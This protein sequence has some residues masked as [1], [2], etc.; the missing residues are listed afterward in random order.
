M[1]QIVLAPDTSAAAAETSKRRPWHAVVRA[2]RGSGSA[3]VGFFVMVTLVVVAVAS[4]LLASGDPR[5]PVG[6]RF[7][8]PSFAHPFGTDDVGADMLDL[9]I[10]A[11]SISLIIGFVTALL[12][13]SIGVF[14]GVLAGYYGGRAD[15]VVARFVDFFLVIP[16]IA[17]VLVIIAVFPPPALWKMILVLSI[18]LWTWTARVMRAQTK[19]VKERVYVRRSIALGGSNL[20]TITKHVLPQ[21]APLIV[22]NVVLTVAVA[23]FFETALAFLGLGDPTALSLGRLIDNA[24]SRGAVTNG[25]WWAIVIPGAFVAIII[26]SLT[27]M[28]TAVE[29]SLNPRLKVSHLTRRSFLMLPQRRGADERVGG[30][31]KVKRS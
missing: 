30:E 11:L 21:L 24:S 23:I 7:A 22:V 4:P 20:W 27:L 10:H 28:G 14:F 2:V 29:D 13:V 18:L 6:D 26:M 9:V 3:M 19:S 31:A 15:T 12:A 17:L 1:T 5:V 25:A 8:P 16:D